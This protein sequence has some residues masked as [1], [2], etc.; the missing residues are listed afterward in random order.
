ME[1]NLTIRLFDE[2]RSRVQVSPKAKEKLNSPQSYFAYRSTLE[3]KNIVDVGFLDF[4]LNVL[5]SDIDEMIID[6][7][8]PSFINEV[9]LFCVVTNTLQRFID[10]DLEYD[11]NC[12]KLY[13]V[14]KKMRAKYPFLPQETNGFQDY[15]QSRE[16][17][18]K[19]EAWRTTAEGCIYCFKEG[20]VFS[21]G[22]MYSCRCCRRSWR[23][24]SS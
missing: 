23:K 3:D 17:R 18:R 6:C 12:V 1:E 5:G 16:L 10:S 20:T 13:R 7:C 15:L 14:Y 9:T 24:P 19:V 4:F 2:L 21:N 11:P 22:N 8:P